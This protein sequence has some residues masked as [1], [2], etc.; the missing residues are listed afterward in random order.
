MMSSSLNITGK[1]EPEIVEIFQTVSAVVNELQMP[2]VVVG[3]TARDLVLHYGHGAK[4]ERATGDIDFAMEVSDW[5]AFDVLK[6]KLIEQRFRETRRQHRLIGPNDTIVDIVPFGAIEVGDATI[7]WPPNG[8]VTM[9]VLGFREACDNAEWVCIQEKPELNIPV[10]TPVGMVLLKLIAWTDRARELR[11]KDA[12]DIAYLFSTYEKIPE[13]LDA[14]YDE[15]NAEVMETYEWDITQ[16]AAYM[17]GQHAKNIAQANTRREV[18]KL[19]GGELGELNLERL[20]EEM[21]EHINVQFARNQ[22]LLTAFI[23]GFNQQ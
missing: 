21:C 12:T 20:A 16:A 18:A 1:V 11:K 14:L 15:S 22:Q 6:C 4:I 17:L 7:N 8:D 2:Y 23:A 5:M 19:A 10:A 3:A 13:V 9:N